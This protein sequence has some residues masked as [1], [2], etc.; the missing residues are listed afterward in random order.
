MNN[1]ETII[2][3]EAKGDLY[4]YEAG[5]GLAYTYGG[6]EHYEFG[7]TVEEVKALVTELT[8]N[9]AALAEA[10]RELAELRGKGK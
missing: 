1:I 9:R 8:A 10:E 5:D 7:A 4:Y 6:C 3:S 2:D